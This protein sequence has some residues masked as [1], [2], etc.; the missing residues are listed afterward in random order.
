MRNET[1]GKRKRYVVKQT[2]QRVKI[3]RAQVTR[4][5]ER[6]KEVNESDRDCGCAQDTVRQGEV[7]CSSVAWCFAV[8][9]CEG[10]CGTTDAQ[11]VQVSALWTRVSWFVAARCRRFLM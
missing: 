9:R 11:G 6:A 3:D 8:V 10:E 4:E 2:Q 5:R 1:S 7:C